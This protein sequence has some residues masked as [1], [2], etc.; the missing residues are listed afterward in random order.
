MRGEGD[1][2]SPSRCPCGNRLRRARLGTDGAESSAGRGVSRKWSERAR[3]GGR[4]IA[5]LWRLT[6]KGAVA[7]L[8]KRSGSPESRLDAFPFCGGGSAI[9]LRA[10]LRVRRSGLDPCRGEEREGGIWFRG[11]TIAGW[12][13]GCFFCSGPPLHRLHAAAGRASQ[14]EAAAFAQVVLA[15][16]SRRQV[17]VGLPVRPSGAPEIAAR[18][19]ARCW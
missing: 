16:G 2:S 18:P 4:R 8:P 17:P 10:G 19:S 13:R 11:G 14:P 5:R 15:S 9:P 6:G 1:A 12:R 3:A 7:D